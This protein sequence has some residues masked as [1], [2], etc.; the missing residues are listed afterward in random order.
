MNEKQKEVVDQY[1]IVVENSYRSRGCLQLVTDQGLFMLTPYNGSPLRLACEYELQKKL[2]EVGFC[3]LDL[4]FPNRENGFI[5]Y[6]KYRSPFILK[7]S[8]EGR[9]CSLK[10]EGDIKNACRNLARL[11]QSFRL[12][13]GD[14][15]PNRNTT[16]VPLM[17]LNKTRELKRIR[18]YI[19]KSGRRTAF[20]LTFTSCY[21]YFYKE[22]E[23]TLNWAGKQKDSLWSRGYGICHGAYHQHNILMEKDRTITLNLGQ[24]HY[25]QQILD[26][27]NLMRKA[28]EKNQYQIRIL[29]LGMEAYG[30]LLPLLKEDLTLLYLLFSFPEKFWKIS[31]QYYNSKKCWM[32]PKNLEKLQKTMEQNEKRKKCIDQFYEKYLA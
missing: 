30:E 11:H 12:L 17:I 18:N 7:R 31:N 2:M 8:Y 4:I 15:V 25:N 24:F 10:E 32:P 22:A 9:E 5:T 1:D 16:P 6:D 23:E 19:R 29:E 21:E 27:Y 13:K 28:M 14:P 3:D 26:F 20:E